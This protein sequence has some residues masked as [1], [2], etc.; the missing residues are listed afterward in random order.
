LVPKYSEEFRERVRSFVRAGHS[1]AEACR[2]FGGPALPTVYLW[3]GYRPPHAKVRA[4]AARV[5]MD[6]VGRRFRPSWELKRAIV[7]RHVDGG[8]RMAD[9]AASTGYSQTVLYNWARKY[10]DGGSEA[11]MSQ[12]ERK[13]AG[14]GQAHAGDDN[15]EGRATKKTATARDSGLSPRERGL[16]RELRRLRMEVDVLKE[17]MGLL[18]KDPGV[19]HAALTNMERFVVANA[20][21]DRWPAG[22]LCRLIGLPRSCYY[23]HLS[24]QGARE[25]KARLREQTG[26]ALRA[27]FEANWR[28][29][30]YRRLHDALGQQGAKVSEGLVRSLMN[31]LGMH[32]RTPRKRKYSSYQGEISPAAPN[33]LERDF[34]AVVPGVKLLTDITEFAL[35]DGELYLSPI[36]DCYDGRILTYTMGSSPDA[37]LVNTMLEQLRDVLPEGA[38]PTI[39]SDQ[40][41][42]Y[43]WPGWTRLMKEY[44]W[45]RSTSRR[46][47]SPD[48][49]ACE[50]FF[51]RLKNEMFHNRDH[52]DATVDEFEKTLARHIEWYNTTRIKRSLG[53]TSPD[54]YRRS[55]GLIA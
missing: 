8:E 45:T 22:D 6:G 14:D 48:N 53:S 43:Q 42:H 34:H 25:A 28:A 2:E 12:D 26:S 18:K 5:S 15:A 38:R 3:L 37:Q 19:D 55:L 46:G 4:P 7:L 54:Q 16:E 10:R 27:V 9:L 24:R 13:H 21:S 51:G 50:G 30:G 36:V 49:S 20:L 39:H 29:Y 1:P 41:C 35:A 44:K 40:G 23:Y 31:E 52:R 32:P 17:T 47:C 33:L 11:L